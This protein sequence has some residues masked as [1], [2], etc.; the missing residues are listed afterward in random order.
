[1]QQL[2]PS[3]SAAA[4][5]RERYASLFQTPDLLP[6]QLDIPGARLLLALV[7]EPVYREAGFLDQ[8][9]NLDGK[10]QAIWAPLDRL[11]ADHHA[12]P[13]APS[14]ARFIFH[15]GHCGS[16]LLSRLLAENPQLL[17]LREPLSLRTL[18]EHERM[19][20]APGALGDG[21]ES[22]ALMG[23]LLRLLTRAY[24]GDQRVLIKPSSNCNNLIGPLLASHAGHKATFLYLNLR[25]YLASVLRPQSR[26]ALHAFSKERSFDLHH[27]M[28]H[29][30]IEPEGLSPAR[31]G[32]A[33]WATSMAY[34]IH[35]QEDR[36]LSARIRLVEFESFLRNPTDSLT[37]L[38]L[39][40]DHPVKRGM[41]ESILQS[42]LMDRYAKDPRIGYTPELRAADLELSLQVHRNDI[43]DAQTWIVDLLAREPRLAVLKD[44]VSGG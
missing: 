38:F 31:L 11:L 4:D 44:L 18:A 37:D 3:Q 30:G 39:F 2:G 9:L 26:G 1:M 27:L 32:A 29:A 13:S 36:Q 24:Q 28:P 22:Q 7:S 35:A 43:D 25:S 8:R 21:S 19:L 6:W 17:P 20:H 33:N 40:L 34:L 42:G 23:L 12:A 10:L 14:P 16:T 5:L 41:V 15:V